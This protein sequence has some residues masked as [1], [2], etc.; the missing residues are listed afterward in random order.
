MGDLLLVF[1]FFL[2]LCYVYVSYLPCVWVNRWD[3]RP[4]V[5]DGNNTRD[6]TG[7]GK[8]VCKRVEVWIWRIFFMWVVVELFGFQQVQV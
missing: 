5:A 2:L 7:M 8:L 6:R 4:T 1:V 3:E